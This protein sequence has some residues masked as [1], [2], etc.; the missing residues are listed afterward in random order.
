MIVYNS[1]NHH[2][3]IEEMMECLKQPGDRHSLAELATVIGEIVDRNPEF[4][5]RIQEIVE[6]YEQK[7]TKNSR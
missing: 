4:V 6:N 5:E 2:L 1:S 7:N 3:S